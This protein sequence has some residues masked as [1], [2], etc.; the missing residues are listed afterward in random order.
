MGAAGG[1]GADSTPLDA[2]LDE[3]AHLVPETSRVKSTDEDFSSGAVIDDASTGYGLRRYTADHARDYCLAIAVDYVRNA[4][5]LADFE[6]DAQFKS[7]TR[8]GALEMG[9]IGR[10]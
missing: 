3:D 9:I 8:L 7:E 6:C 10:P 1:V 5:L 2:A 4:D